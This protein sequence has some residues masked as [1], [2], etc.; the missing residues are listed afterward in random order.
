MSGRWLAARA[1]V[2]AVGLGMAGIGLGQGAPF[3]GQVTPTQ[4]FTMET[5]EI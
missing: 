1:L 4:P 2:L 5:F 3:A